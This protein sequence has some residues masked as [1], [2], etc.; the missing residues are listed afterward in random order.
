MSDTQQV[1]SCHICE[2]ACP[3]APGS[4]GL[5]GRYGN[6]DGVIT[7]LYPNTYIMA[8]PIRIETMPMLH[9]HPGA[10]FLQVST[11]GCNFDC[12]GCI[13]AVIVREM[14]PQSKALQEYS[15]EQIVEKAILSGCR[16]ITFLMNDPLAAFETFL[17]V[18]TLAKARGLHV[19]CSSNGYFSKESI[20]RIL[21]VLD[22]INIGVKGL[23]DEAYHVCSG[24]KGFAPVLR[25]IK[26]LHEGG[27]HIEIACIHRKG[28]EDELLRLCSIIKDISPVIPLQMMRFI[29]LEG[30]DPEQE[31]L[32][33]ESETLSK[34]MRTILD[35]VYV[36]NSP[37][38][39]ELNTVCP[40][41]GDT[42]IVRD[43]YGPMGAR[44]KG[45]AVREA[46][47]PLCLA[48]DSPVQIQGRVFDIDFREKD[49][50]G[51]YP[52]TRAL[53]IVESI[54]IAI[55]VSSK[56]EVVHVWEYLLCNNKMQDLHHDIQR[57]ES[58]IHMIR[59][60]GSLVHREESADVLANYLEDKVSLVRSTCRQDGKRP[61]VYYAMGKPQF[62]IK[63]ERFENHLV[64]LCNGVSVNREIEICGRPGM[65]IALDTLQQLNPEI[66]FISAFISNSPIDFYN[67]CVDKGLGID[68]VH[69]KRI[70]TAPI[71][72]SDFG[73]P[74][75]IL[76]LM[77][78]A[79]EM[80]RGVCAFDI[81]G[82]A[83]KFYERFYGT[84]FN[85][86]DVNRSFGKP[87]TSWTWEAEGG[88]PSPTLA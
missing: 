60:F 87:D 19:G 78:I 46:E 34:Q 86:Q 28:H 62:C 63:G 68:A 44:M 59:F 69:N 26:L 4:V 55:G 85:A 83:S 11:V 15:P 37:G 77:N 33:R 82:E 29:P 35:N 41:C 51:G 17:A 25:N 53:E 64:E 88:Q 47:Q 10:R 32:I 36:F 67:E 39:E 40:H 31:P 1:R 42:T 12:P 38:T 16:G 49:F 43:F 79:N 2:N 50:Q 22:F 13:S 14:H 27:V 81:P 6:R 3:V 70:H 48:C 80:H 58:Y 76:G 61:R 72:S 7:E 52:F 45:S 75:W 84:S 23:S 5:C 56:A 57:V 74:K 73:G 30:A 8:C 66:I 18:A 65:S 71:P 21:P 54:L 24:L 20:Q 9:F